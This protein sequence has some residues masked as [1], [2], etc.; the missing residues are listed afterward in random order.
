MRS[1]ICITPLVLAALA[2]AAVINFDDLT[3]SSGGVATPGGV[4]PFVGRTVPSNYSSL[5]T[6][7]VPGG[8][9][10]V[11]VRRTWYARRRWR[12]RVRISV[13]SR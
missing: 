8:A 5:V 6:F 10:F 4:T 11:R 2:P 12:W 7:S 3:A 9:L 13:R 1:L